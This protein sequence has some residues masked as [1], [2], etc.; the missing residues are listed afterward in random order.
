VGGEHD[1]NPPLREGDLV[2][3][4]NGHAV[5]DRTGALGALAAASASVT[6][7][8][9]RQGHQLVRRIATL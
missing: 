8:V 3:S 1:W 4:V 5:A 6:V 2:R 7:V 9:E